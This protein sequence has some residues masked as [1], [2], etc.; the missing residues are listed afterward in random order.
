MKV[1]RKRRIAH[2]IRGGGRPAASE[3]APS[4]AGTA[5]VCA[6]GGEPSGGIPERSWSLLARHGDHRAGERQAEGGH[7]TRWDRGVGETV[8]NGASAYRN[9][10]MK[11]IRLSSNRLMSMQMP[12]SVSD[13][14]NMEMI[15][16]DDDSVQ[17]GQPSSPTTHS[18]EM[19]K[20][21]VVDM[22][23]SVRRRF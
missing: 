15:R 9:S 13:N 1:R 22:K 14:S 18:D 11:S 20:E 7:S 2:G 21:K 10:I 8:G 6:L 12:M 17:S 3:G 19:R 23:M 16:E 4:S 5:S